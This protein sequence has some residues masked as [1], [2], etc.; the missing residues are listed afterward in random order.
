MA[1]TFALVPF[2]SAIVDHAEALGRATLRTTEAIWPASI[3]Q[4][5]KA[6]VLSPK[7]LNEIGERK[8]L[9]VLDSVL[10]HLTNLPWFT[11]TTLGAWRWRC[12]GVRSFVADQVRK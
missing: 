5:G 12:Q 8:P 7:S 9:L 6:L 3:L 11:R 1:T 4:G 10:G 2:A